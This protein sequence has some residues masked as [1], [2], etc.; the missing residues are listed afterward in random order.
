LT[1]YNTLTLS[2]EEPRKKARSSAVYVILG[3]AVVAMAGSAA[4]FV[5]SAAHAQSAVNSEYSA[6]AG[7]VTNC[8]KESNGFLQE[9]PKYDPTLSAGDRDAFYNACYYAFQCCTTSTQECF[10]SENFGMSCIAC[11]QESAPRM[12]KPWCMTYAKKTFD[13]V[14]YP[15]IDESGAEEF[16]VQSLETETFTESGALVVETLPDPASEILVQDLEKFPSYKDETGAEYQT[17]WP[18]PGPNDGRVQTFAQECFD[19]IS[20]CNMLCPRDESNSNG[21]ALCKQCMVMDFKADLASPIGQ[22]PTG[23]ETQA[24]AAVAAEATLTEQGKVQTDWDNVY[25]N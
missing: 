22:I 21:H 12:V 1:S 7:S 25:E 24:N 19:V 10:V 8:D 23:D 18:Q 17:C 20:W 15:T 5:S 16:D 6:E 2:E 9:L 13:M 3:F 14:K 4:V 11:L